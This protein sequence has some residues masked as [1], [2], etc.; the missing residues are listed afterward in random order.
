M[1]VCAR[2]CVLCMR[3]REANVAMNLLLR[4]VCV[5]ASFKVV[6]S[7]RCFQTFRPNPQSNHTNEQ[8]EGLTIK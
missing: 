3:Y 6:G 8:P 5:R 1:S 7:L 2:A 4:L